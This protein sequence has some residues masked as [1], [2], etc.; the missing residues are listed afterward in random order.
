[1][2]TTVPVEVGQR[3]RARAQRML[4]QLAHAARD[5]INA[6]THH[7]VEVTL[8]GI[9]V[10]MH[11]RV[12]CP[13]RRA[14]MAVLAAAVAAAVA[15]GALRSSAPHDPASQQQLGARYDRNEENYTAADTINIIS[16][17]PVHGGAADN[18]SAAEYTPQP[19]AT[20]VFLI[21]TAHGASD[22]WRNCCMLLASRPLHLPR[23]RLF[24]RIVVGVLSST[25]EPQLW[26]LV[27]VCH[28]PLPSFTF[29]CPKSHAVL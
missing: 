13:R 18:I 8:P 12:A 26:R 4:Q 24:A 27:I 17:T 14:V 5:S 20:F 19:G 25:R 9:A 23:G 6:A 28:F 3:P 10:T 22:W 2:E 15:T 1:M 16:A 21:E 29:A 7:V 11:E